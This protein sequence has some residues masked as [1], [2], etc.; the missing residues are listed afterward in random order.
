MAMTM[1][2]KAS[3]CVPGTVLS[4]THILDSITT[5]P[6]WGNLKIAS[7]VWGN[8]GLKILVPMVTQLLC[9]WIR[10]MNLYL[11][12][13]QTGFCLI[14]ILLLLYLSCCL[15]SEP[16]LF[17]AYYKGTTAHKGEPVVYVLN[18]FSKEK[19]NQTSLNIPG[20][21]YAL[22]LAICCIVVSCRHVVRTKDGM[23]RWAQ[24]MEDIANVKTR[25]SKKMNEDVYILKQRC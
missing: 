17:S 15:T 19:L 6:L 11:P 18:H 23:W 12:D 25:S 21:F 2:I 16:Q 3:F 1:M 8:W 9:V 14:W 10:N 13:S 20:R 5:C 7:H 22:V 24:L 4:V